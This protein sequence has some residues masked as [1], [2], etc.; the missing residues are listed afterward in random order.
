MGRKKKYNSETERKA[1]LALNK[2]LK[3]SSE[4][5]QKL[6]QETNNQWISQ[7]LLEIANQVTQNVERRTADK[8]QRAKKR[9][10]VKEAA[11]VL[12]HQK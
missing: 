7:Y 1:A 3:R 2:K 10:A 11:N 6:A 5:E 8:K 9:L 4:K 12:Q